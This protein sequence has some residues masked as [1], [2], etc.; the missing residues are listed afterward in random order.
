MEIKDKI[1]RTLKEITAVPSV[2]GT[3]GEKVMAD[4]LYDIISSMDYFRANKENCGLEAIDNDPLGRSFVW[5]MV[6]SGEGSKDTVI[7][8]THLDVVGTEGYGHLQPVAYDIEECTARIS[9]LTF[10]DDAIKDAESGEWIFGRGSADIKSGIA[11]YMEIIRELSEKRDFKGNLLL[12]LVPGEESNSEGMI[13]AIP[14]LLKLQEEKGCN[15]VGATVCESSIPKNK[16]EDFKRLYL[17]S[18][19]K[20]MPMFFCAGKETHAGEPFGG[21]NPNSFVSEIQRRLELNPDFC[22]IAGKQTTPPPVSLKQTDLKK[23]YSVSTPMFAVSYYNLL[24]LT[25]T[26]EQLSNELK[27]LAREAFVSVLID[28]EDKRQR[29]SEMSSEQFHYAEVE[30]C[31]MSYQELLAQVRSNDE[32]FDEWIKGRI[33]V[34]KREKLDNQT[35]AINIVKETYEKYDDERPMIILS[36]IPPFYPHICLKDS[37][38]KDRRFI[39]TIDKVIKYAEESFN[40]KIVKEQY[41]MGISDLS[42]TGIDE[43]QDLDS[44]AANIVGYGINYDLY[45]E[46]LSKLDIPGIVFGG[47]GKD[48]HK[49]TERLN[50]DYSLRVLPELYKHLIYSLL[51]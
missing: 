32:N 43:N 11:I 34:W 14:F 24:T 6:S 20:I 49:S 51:K 23:L 13:S 15:F 3:E 45:L 12:L 48:I 33:E 9:E 19:G 30:S 50:V 44:L 39:E 8:T 27:D 42:Y 35:I 31:V 38:A 22:D 4:K 41:F 36:Y 1:Y 28:V 47:E 2:S 17:G 18:V 16:N 40:E 26:V 7:L 10:D 5:A 37:K 46:A 29:F 21:L 25:R